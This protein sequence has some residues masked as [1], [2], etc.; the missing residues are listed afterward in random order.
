MPTTLAAIDIGSN[1]IRLSV[2]RIET[3]RNL[4]V[5]DNFREPLRLGR[6]VFTRRIISEDTSEAALDVFRRFKEIIDRNSVTFTKAAATSALREATNA[7]SFIDKISHVSGIDID[8]ISPEE[9]ARLIHLAIAGRVNLK[10][11]TALLID[12]GG[13]ST[14]IT[15]T[16]D[17]SI[18]STESYRLGAVRLL[19]LLEEKKQGEKKFNALVQEY[20]GATRGRLTK[21]IKG[22]KIDLC[23]GTG[24]NIEALAVIKKEVL[25]KDKNGTVSVEDLSSILKKLMSLSFDERMQQFR[26]RPDRA[27][28]I[29]PASIILQEIIKIAGIEEVV[30]PRV[31]LKEGLMI[32]MAQTVFG[33]QKHSNR[34][35]VLTSALEL[36]RKYSFDEQHGTSVARYAVDLFDQTRD[37]HN[38]GLEHR[39]LLEAAAILHDVGTFISMTGHH[40]HTYYLLTANPIIGFGQ[41]Q[42][43]IVANVARYHRKSFPKIQHEPFRELSPKDRVVVSK[44]AAILRLADAMDNEHASR[45]DSFIAEYKK[46]KLMIRIRGNGDLLLEKWA[47]M[48][49][50]ELFESVFGV[51]VSIED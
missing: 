47:L 12:I 5:L 41:S 26:L 33:E 48:N 24:G 36:G 20:V 46:P 18:V 45:V 42:S 23:I 2:G 51:K 7:D 3:D 21:E 22:K 50:A 44:L 19:Q 43:R 34:D 29:V 15:L 49:K 6:D 1:A 40:K 13:G 8:V 11:K 38:L 25:E 9:E 4:T 17:G 39:L 27:D 35:Q 31:G 30:V 14:E 16:Y 32:D 37:L 28:V 10:N